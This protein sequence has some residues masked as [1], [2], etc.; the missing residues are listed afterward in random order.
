[1]TAFIV[2]VRIPDLGPTTEGAM[3]LYVAV[4]SNEAEAL[5]QVAAIIP[6]AWAVEDVVGIAL[7]SL[8]ERRK[9]RDG[10]VERL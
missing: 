5:S 6:K 10:S 9:L 3:T 1:M 4:V 2:R 7:P 8:V